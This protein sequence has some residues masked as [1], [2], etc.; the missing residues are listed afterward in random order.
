MKKRL[1]GFAWLCLLV[2]ALGAGQDANLKLPD[3]RALSAK[4][5]ES[6]NISLGPWLL[7]LAGAFIDGKDQD[8]AAT[9]QLLAGIRSIQIRSY[10]F[11]TDFAYS[12][13]DIDA[14]RSQL[15]APGWSQLIQAH[16]AKGQDVD[17]YIMIENNVTK[18]LAVIA[19][20]PREFTIINIVGSIK[21]DDLPALE[22]QLHLPKAAPPR[23]GLLM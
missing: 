7:H 21:L 11:A 14:V 18:G 23:A 1:F 9:K 22:N 4:A 10:E 19:R 12:A 20:E 2:P 6:V 5:T 3:F 13:A 8:A 15:A 16:D 17:V